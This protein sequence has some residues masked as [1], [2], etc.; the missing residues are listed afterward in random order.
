[1]KSFLF[2]AM[3]ISVFSGLQA[4]GSQICSYYSGKSDPDIQ[5]IEKSISATSNDNLDSDAIV[6]CDADKSVACYAMFTS[7]HKKIEIIS[8]GC[9]T[10]NASSANSIGA[11]CANENC[12][13]LSSHLVGES[14]SDRNKSRIGFCCCSTR[15][16][17]Q[18]I[19]KPIV[20]KAVPVPVY[21]VSKQ[22]LD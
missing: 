19:T 18:I 8:A 22:I 20:R 16:C 7:T 4:S 9:L 10:M 1:M 14:D 12:T 5:K 13:A 6:I 21:E 15:L 11:T 2:L 17:N 3:F